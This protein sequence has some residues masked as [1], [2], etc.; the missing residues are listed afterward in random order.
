MYHFFLS[1]IQHYFNILL[2]Y[3]WHTTSP[4]HT[5]V[6]SS[7]SPDPP[8]QSPTTPDPSPDLPDL[9][10]C[11]PEPSAVSPNPCMLS[12]ISIQSNQPLLS[13]TTSPKPVWQFSVMLTLSNLILCPIGLQPLSNASGSFPAPSPTLSDWYLAQK[14]SLKP[15]GP[16]PVIPTYA[17]LPRPILLL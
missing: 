8:E 5:L 7:D 4:G 6:V 17:D 13:P 3:P 16:S 15:Y 14:T 2:L 11:I 10:I 12:P 9:C 1:E